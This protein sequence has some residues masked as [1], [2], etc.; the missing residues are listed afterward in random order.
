MRR[1]RSR[2]PTSILH[3]LCHIVISVACI[4]TQIC[5]PVAAGFGQ[6]I[7]H[8]VIHPLGSSESVDS[9]HSTNPTTLLIPDH[10]G[11]K[12]EV[13]Q[14]ES[15][16]HTH[17]PVRVVI[18]LQDIHT[19]PDAQKALAELIDL[20]HQSS[21]VS[22]IA[23]EGGSGP[24]DTQFFSSFPDPD[25]NR[26]LADF[27][28]NK[29]LFTGPVSY[30]VTH[31]GTVNLYGVEDAKLYLDHLSTY[32]AAYRKQK[33][34]ALHLDALA[35]VLEQLEDQLYS[36]QLKAL[37]K[38]S[39]QYEAGT[40]DI[41]HYLDGLKRLSDKWQMSLESYPNLTQMLWLMKL[42]EQ[43]DPYAVEQEHRHLLEALTRKLSQT[44]IQ[45]LL[46]HQLSFRSGKISEAQYYTGL[47]RFAQKAGIFL[48]SAQ[49]RETSVVS[50]AIR[51]FNE[52]LGLFPAGAYAHLGAYTD[53]LAVAET[54]RY[55]PL[56]SELDHLS[57]AIKDR[58]LIDLQQRHLDQLL[59]IL[60]VLKD[61][62]T[63]RLF[64]PQLAYY[65][66]HKADFT[67]GSFLSFLAAHQRLTPQLRQSLERVFE[68]LSDQERFYELATKRD[69]ALAAN[70]LK[71]MEDHHQQTAI[72]VTGGFHT[73]GI[74]RLL[75]EQGVAY[76]VISPAGGGEV[77]EDLYS[78]L[79]FDRLPPL[80]QL[81]SEFA[82][83]LARAPLAKNHP[84]T[85]ISPVCAFADPKPEIQDRVQE[86]WTQ[87]HVEASFAKGWSPQEIQ[88]IYPEAHPTLK[89]LD[90]TAVATGNR[91]AKISVNGKTAT[92]SKS[93][94][95]IELVSIEQTPTTPA[96]PAAWLSRLKQKERAGNVTADDIERLHD[97]FVTE[98]LP[99]GALSFYVGFLA[100]ERF[101][102]DEATRSLAIRYSNEYSQRAA[103]IKAMADAEAVDINA[104][105]ADQL[106]DQLA[107]LLR[108]IV[109]D[110][111]SRHKLIDRIIQ[112]R[113]FSTLEDLGRV[114]GIGK[115]RLK[116]I[117]NQ[118][119]SRIQFGQGTGQEEPTQT[120]PP[121]PILTPLPD[122]VRTIFPFF[123]QTA[124][125]AQWAIDELRRSLEGIETDR[126]ITVWLEWAHPSGM[127]GDVSKV[128]RFFEQMIGSEMRRKGYPMNW[129]LE[130]MRSPMQ[131]LYRDILK[132]AFD[133]FQ[134]EQDS[135]SV[136]AIL[137]K[138]NHP[139][140][141]GLREGIETLR[142]EGWNIEVR[143]E[144]PSFEGY[145]N[146]LREQVRRLKIY[147]FLIQGRAQDAFDSLALAVDDLTKAMSL[148][149][150][151]LGL[152]I[153]QNQQDH[154]E[155]LQ[156]VFRGTAYAQTIAKVLTV[157]KI[158]QRSVVQIPSRAPTF[159]RVW[160]RYL[161][162]GAPSAR[163][164]QGR[165]LMMEMLLGLSL[166]RL[167]AEVEVELTQEERQLSPQW[168]RLLVN[169]PDSLIES[170]FAQ[171]AHQ[172]SDD[173][174]LLRAITWSWLKRQRAVLS[175][176]AA[177]RLEAI[178]HVMEQQRLLGQ[179]AVSVGSKTEES[180]PQQGPTTAS[181]SQS[182]PQ[183]F[184]A[185]KL[186]GNR[187]AVDVAR[188]VRQRSTN[189]QPVPMV[190][191]E[192][193]K[194]EAVFEMDPAERQE[195]S[196]ALGLS[197]AELGALITRAFETLA[198]RW[199]IDPRRIQSK[200][201]LL[202]LL[203][204]DASRHMFEDHAENLIEDR[205]NILGFVGINRTLLK[206]A[207]D[208]PKIAQA[209]FVVGLAHELRHEAG[210]TEEHVDWDAQWMVELLQEA[211]FTV[212]DW[213]NTLDSH[214]DPNA[215]E[216][217]GFADAVLDAWVK[218][219][220]EISD[221]LH[222]GEPKPITQEM[223]NALQEEI[224][225]QGIPISLPKDRLEKLLAHPGA[226]TAVE[227]NRILKGIQL[228]KGWAERI[229]Q[230]ANKLK[231]IEVVVRPRKD[232]QTQLVKQITELFIRASREWVR[233]DLRPAH[234]EDLRA[235]RLELFT[236]PGG[237]NVW[238]IA[239]RHWD[240][241]AMGL[242]AKVIVGTGDEVTDIS[243]LP[244]VIQ[245]KSQAVN[246]HL[247]QW[248]EQARTG[249]WLFV[250]EPM[251]GQ[252]PAQMPVDSREIV[253][254]LAKL[255]RLPVVEALNMADWEVIHQ[256]H[257]ATRQQGITEADL[258]GYLVEA[259]LA[260][261]PNVRTPQA[262]RQVLEGVMR[263][264]ANS[265]R[266]Q[267]LYQ[268]DENFQRFKN[269][270]HLLQTYADFIRQ[271]RAEQ[272]RRLQ[273]ISDYSLPIADRLT[274]ER[275]QQAL[276]GN[277]KIKDV[278]MIAGARHVEAL[279]GQP[280]SSSPPQPGSMAAPEAAQGS[281]PSTENL[282][283]QEQ[284][285]LRRSL[286][287]MKTYLQGYARAY[288]T[289]QLWMEKLIEAKTQ[290]FLL[291]SPAE[292]RAAERVYMSILEP[293]AAQ[294]R[295]AYAMAEGRQPTYGPSLQ[296]IEQFAAAKEA[297][298]E[299][300]GL[301]N[302]L[303]L[304]KQE[305][306]Q[307]FRASGAVSDSVEKL[308]KLRQ[309]LQ[310]CIMALDRLFPSAADPSATAAS[311]P[312]HPAS[313]ESASVS[314]FVERILELFRRAADT[315]SSHPRP[316]S[317]ASQD[318]FAFHG[319][320]VSAIADAHGDPRAKN[321]LMQ[322]LFGIPNLDN[323]DPD[324]ARQ[325]LE[326]FVEEALAGKWL[327]A[328]EAVEEF[329]QGPFSAH[330]GDIALQMAKALGIAVVSVPNPSDW[331][332]LRETIALA[333]AEGVSEEDVA[334]LNMSSRL[335]L[336]SE[337]QWVQ[338][339]QQE[340]E[341]ASQAESQ[342]LHLPQGQAPDELYQRFKDPAFLTRAFLQ[343]RA[344]PI[345]EINR[346]SE[347]IM[348]HVL[349]ASDRLLRQR[350][351][352]AILNHP[353]IEK[354]L[355]IAGYAHVDALKA[356]SSQAPQSGNAPAGSTQPPSA[357]QPRDP[358]HAGEPKPVTDIRVLEQVVL[359]PI[360]LLVHG[361]GREMEVE[362]YRKIRREGL[363][364]SAVTGV[365]A[366]TVF[367]DK[368]SLSL[369]RDQVVSASALTTYG[370][371]ANPG[372]IAFVIH[373]AY[374]QA[375]RDQF[376]V[377]GSGLSE[378][379]DEYT[380]G[381]R[382][383][384]LDQQ[385]DALADVIDLVPI[386]DEIQVS[387]VPPEAISGVLV[388]VE[389]ADEVF[390]WEEELKAS[391]LD[392]LPIYVLSSP[393]VQELGP[394][395]PVDSHRV[396]I[397]D[398]LHA[399]ETGT[400]KQSLKDY[401]IRSLYN[402]IIQAVPK[403]KSSLRMDLVRAL[404]KYE[405]LT[406]AAVEKVV[407]RSMI[408]G[409][410]LTSDDLKKVTEV[411]RDFMPQQEIKPPQPQWGVIYASHITKPNFA[412]IRPEFDRLFERLGGKR[413]KLTVIL[414]ETVA[415]SMT[416]RYL[417]P[418]VQELYYG[419]LLQ[420]GY[421]HDPW[422]RQRA[423]DLI[424]TLANDRRFI[425]TAM[426]DK[427]MSL[428]EFLQ[429]IRPV[430][431]SFTIAFVEY[432]LEN[433]R[434]GYD[435]E[436]DWEKTDVDSTLQG[437]RY[438]YLYHLAMVSLEQGNRE[439][440]LRYVAKSHRAIGLGIA[441][442]DFHL[443]GQQLPMIHSR[444]RIPIMTR[445]LNH[446]GAERNVPERLAGRTVNTTKTVGT[447]VDL[448]GP[449]DKVVRAW[450]T[451]EPLD[452]AMEEEL[453]LQEAVF[454]IFE[455]AL[456]P[457]EQIAYLTW[458]APALAVVKA[459]P[460]ERVSELFVQIQSVAGQS[461]AGSL[462]SEQMATLTLEWLRRLDIPAIQDALPKL[463]EV[464]NARFRH[465]LGV[466]RDPL[467]AGEGTK[468]AIIEVPGGLHEGISLVGIFGNQD[469]ARMFEEEL[470]KAGFTKLRIRDN[471]QAPGLVWIDMIQP[472]QLGGSWAVAEGE[473][474][475]YTHFAE[476]LSSVYRADSSPGHAETRTLIASLLRIEQARIRWAA[477]QRDSLEA[478]K[479]A[480]RDKLFTPTE[481]EQLSADDIEQSLRQYIKHQLASQS[482]FASQ[483]LLDH[484]LQ[485]DG[486]RKPGEIKE[487][488]LEDLARFLWMA[489]IFRNRDDYTA[490]HDAGAFR[491]WVRSIVAEE[492]GSR[493]TQG[494]LQW[495]K[496]AFIDSL[497]EKI[498]QLDQR[499]SPRDPL[500][501]GERRGQDKAEAEAHRSLEQAERLAV[502]LLREKAS[503]N[504]SEVL[505]TFEEL[506]AIA[507]SKRNSL[508]L[509]E[510]ATAFMA[511]LAVVIVEKRLATAPEAVRRI[512]D[513]TVEQV[514][515]ILVQQ[516]DAPQ[517][518]QGMRQFHLA[519]LCR[520]RN[521]FPAAWQHWAKATRLIAVE[522]IGSS[523][524]P[525]LQMV[526]EELA[527]ISTQ[528]QRRLSEDEAHRFLLEKILAVWPSPFVLENLL[529]SGRV[530][531]NRLLGVIHSVLQNPSDSLH[532]RLLIHLQEAKDTPHCRLIRQLET[533]RE[534]RAILSGLLD[535]TDE[536]RDPIHV[537]EP[538]TGVLSVQED[539]GNRRWVEDQLEHFLQQ[540]GQAPQDQRPQIIQQ[541]ER[542]QQVLYQRWKNPKTRERW[543][544]NA[545]A[546]LSDSLSQAK[547]LLQAADQASG[548]SQK[549]G[550]GSA[551]GQT[552]IRPRFLKLADAGS[553]A[554]QD[555]RALNFPTETD[556]I[557]TAAAQVRQV[558]QQPVIIPADLLE[559]YGLPETLR[560]SVYIDPGFLEYISQD[561]LLA[562]L[563]EALA[564]EHRR[565]PQISIQNLQHK[566]L[567][568]LLADEY[569]YLAG[570]HTADGV[571]L[572]RRN[573]T[574]ADTQFGKYSPQARA[575][576]RSLLLTAFAHQW[577]AHELPGLGS[578]ADT[579]ERTARDLENLSFFAGPHRDLIQQFLNQP[580]LL[581]GPLELPADPT[582]NDPIDALFVRLLR[583]SVL[584]PGA[585]AGYGQFP[586]PGVEVHGLSLEHR[587]ERAL[588]VLHDSIAPFVREHPEEWLFIVEMPSEEDRR[589][590]E[591]LS[592]LV[593][594][595]GMP[596]EASFAEELGRLWGI[597][598]VSPIL[599]VHDRRVLEYAA[600][601]GF[602]TQ[603]AFQAAFLDHQAYTQE[604]THRDPTDEQSEFLIKQTARRWNV[605][606]QTLRQAAQDALELERRDPQGALRLRQF[607]MNFLT[608]VSN[609][610]TRQALENVLHANA[611]K[612]KI[613]IIAGSSHTGSVASF[614]ASHPI[615]APRPE[616]EV[617]VSLPPLIEGLFQQAR[618]VHPGSLD[619]S[620]IGRSHLE[621]FDFLGHRVMGIAEIH[622]DPYA[623]NLLQQISRMELGGASFMEQARAA[624]VLFAVEGAGLAM[625]QEFAGEAG[626]TAVRLAGTLNI[627][628][629]NPISNPSH[630]NV[631]R[632]VIQEGKGTGEF[633]LEDVAGYYVGSTAYQLTHGNVREAAR[634][635]A[636]TWG[637]LTQGE[638]L[639]AFQQFNSLSHDEQMRKAQ[640]IAGYSV[641]VADRLTHDALKQIIEQQ[642]PQ[643]QHIVL[644]AG[645]RHV[646][647]LKAFAQTVPPSSAD[648]GGTSVATRQ[649]APSEPQQADGADAS[650]PETRDPLHAGEPRGSQ[651]LSTQ[652]AEA[653]KTVPEQLVFSVFQHDPILRE[654]AGSGAGLLEKATEGG[655]RPLVYLVGTEAIKTV[656][657]LATLVTLRDQITAS[658]TDKLV[659]IL[660][661]HSDP[662]LSQAEL[663]ERLPI[664]AEKLF[665]GTFDGMPVVQET[666][667]VIRS[668]LTQALR[669]QILQTVTANL[670][671]YRQA[672]RTR[673]GQ[674]AEVKPLQ[675]L[676]HENTVT[677]ASHADEQWIFHTLLEDTRHVWVQP[678]IR[679]DEP[680]VADYST[681][682]MRTLTVLSESK[683]TSAEL[684]GPGLK[685]TVEN[686]V[687][688]IQEGPDILIIPPRS[689]EAGRLLH[690]IDK[691]FKAQRLVRSQV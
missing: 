643:V 65:Q 198:Q 595:T 522:Q 571:I 287:D 229:A 353:S 690:S 440:Y 86:D 655:K 598:V 585:R 661:V 467:H 280:S 501:A 348:R 453:L 359:R 285:R 244:D 87:G 183:H 546:K 151:T 376:V 597:P 638:L 47:E 478:K 192:N 603:H 63:L 373:P 106:Q 40:L 15:P 77:D 408:R 552:Q 105:A 27:F 594:E 612:Q 424:N 329:E 186:S 96:E 294:S 125:D 253:S 136:E 315:D 516:P 490:S 417:P 310:L 606:E 518:V 209:L 133:G 262:M 575:I 239:E 23:M 312:T 685:H 8:Q 605:D 225:K 101:A 627:P 207:Q 226:L 443:F 180:T 156:I 670:K 539:Y 620:H 284:A 528:R 369:S 293:L 609:R 512:L 311:N 541:G 615:A 271:P 492:V 458:V 81:L 361:V 201:V 621:T 617:P 658:K 462:S 177:D 114:P 510:Q 549:A 485:S 171:I 256:T 642:Y 41:T 626:Q 610:F 425:A 57:G 203:N 269:V 316:A 146:H 388:S 454:H 39:A 313:P 469:L 152:Q 441:V 629:V 308:K 121:R 411:V 33:D 341:Q 579:D 495:F 397:R 547:G 178:E 277:P 11:H 110:E 613:L 124:G 563:A 325:T 184:E 222:A 82:T 672:Y 624:H 475:F 53:S 70:T 581:V 56:A 102:A 689:G 331:A 89:Q 328:I 299:F 649:K 74:T 448:M 362:R 94:E 115:G 7:Q 565:D 526:N 466:T 190:A 160:T 421:L 531:R 17:L 489:K 505:R 37:I 129:A 390:Q 592:G 5:P 200:K 112:L 162:E 93:G 497:V 173:L 295:A 321:L 12:V 632:E 508:K 145:L 130:L 260:Y 504:P 482:Y 172:R 451:N 499:L 415:L 61:L 213:I 473:L 340:I 4:N 640:Q 247:T 480:L 123:H 438:F 304:R 31:P 452:P 97:L 212:H 141:V 644:L 426:R 486:Q 503:V 219:E 525:V 99:K 305:F 181:S 584:V 339:T 292:A 347:I 677:L 55:D 338:P 44:D 104:A 241:H 26:Q 196:R 345:E 532:A 288:E 444:G 476:M 20:F 335:P 75:R 175:P 554:R 459:V 611:Q 423:Q 436:L 391:G 113:P 633:S 24:G 199:G 457:V 657:G 193:N 537:G 394:Y 660:Y 111:A 493:G 137:I 116:Q 278:L 352:Q 556:A 384:G 586:L 666:D 79:L 91:Q 163:T 268:R 270:S 507:T 323:F 276:D 230:A 3:R 446:A 422:L 346:K 442:R 100:R 134:R 227:A 30:A 119:S 48:T 433:V 687:P 534:I 72:L 273:I 382:M 396:E 170:W 568:I 560:L 319:R 351:E 540:L 543:A 224:K 169:L 437:H 410:K 566:P 237:Q 245:A 195:L 623:L 577:G 664:D 238:G 220:E 43:I 59:S 590:T 34:T 688:A 223:R 456:W 487:R 527:Q 524:A 596:A 684:E 496:P 625:Q 593:G 529:A 471:P 574:D 416:Q 51:A 176:E 83:R 582:A 561:A 375:H 216:V 317:R 399:G 591:D 455:T 653:E 320:S 28:V 326:G 188:E 267:P 355:L 206:I 45:L 602:D 76:V 381:L 255:L 1:L 252:P 29:G 68:D 551:G 272:L 314:L 607:W 645:Y 600:G 217:R 149:D 296:A 289:R 412:L 564:R 166:P 274:R 108:P 393:S 587:S 502:Q 358:L 477:K 67:A 468:V 148:R 635:I 290:I 303:A 155:T 401:E 205:G 372:Y 147:E 143:L 465:P 432:L 371:L 25:T 368:V 682:V 648:A 165:R 650:I 583:A 365:D 669:K 242:L 406:L 420:D 647:A 392:Q 333:K 337:R 214:V 182:Q 324:A 521:D 208:N 62:Y 356:S 231:G 449:G 628:V 378:Q 567:T 211:G 380:Q 251:I 179:E 514:Q 460:S 517:N 511:S 50:H 530:D 307:T 153:A 158:A 555:I 646:D 500:H 663:F 463:L 332:V 419:R 263:N 400:A 403:L 318:S 282:Q 161:A 637:T 309:T 157:H 535:R 414:E 58:L 250:L 298:Q 488:L 641:R 409:Q 439:D 21:G 357:T 302:A 523:L 35:S 494:D 64:H 604:K 599:G 634:R 117:Q 36:K 46:K 297:S 235:S 588:R 618:L 69:E 651:G 474:G 470:S 42:Q 652:P 354:I 218:A 349:N 428:A 78:S 221:P 383:L 327:F 197:D 608:A 665:D 364:P 379:Q 513:Q 572:H 236:L 150:E 126:P 405:T 435:I 232:E 343:F 363:R 630:W 386:P 71:Q 619:P 461:Q 233:L 481:L 550:S 234:P 22:L 350:L 135:K 553:F 654:L 676:S 616:K 189:R 538:K 674:D 484:A 679:V 243:N 98:Q 344:Q 322:I 167:A 279:K 570:N 427:K 84:E 519:C 557:K 342:S 520:F 636:G 9:A 413:A 16:A 450:A 286:E 204:E 85:L 254:Q 366:V 402:Q 506:R 107:E 360:G 576:V 144:P 18:H 479:D 265:L 194:G 374:V 132:K 330:A 686:D 398:P 404:W 258:V 622:Q 445:G 122:P 191:I 249:Q 90:F 300:S 128:Q 139:F 662:T 159:T 334:G 140:L 228:K 281:Q 562:L 202:A 367:P 573:F 32:Q 614:I 387:Q 395:R 548:V 291:R 142:Q 370:P 673:T 681:A 306:D 667:G 639:A 668:S 389:M 542:F 164:R 248:I 109:P 431:D 429:L 138:E 54:L 215:P 536:R 257:E 6:R 259:G 680:A 498:M 430:E 60:A 559:L 491:D 187:Q 675:G 691:Q 434:A 38:M 127:P 578:E 447:S 283:P 472:K 88:T 580:G 168:D 210:T 589:I 19:H 483:F 120:Q 103:G 246:L 418:A 185:L 385:V 131:K 92:Y 407:G 533:F 80:E 174:S 52:S 266:A 558:V 683:Q 544:E 631:I 14:P 154:P 569:E 275:L 261:F 95:S 678:P 601:Q 264:I 118:L 73:E 545:L 377:K 2:R 515:W 13:F 240:P 10:L 671:K 659:N 509:R 66:S 336:P 656:T 464:S 49:R 301:L